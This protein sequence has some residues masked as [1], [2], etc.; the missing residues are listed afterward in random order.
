MIEMVIVPIE[1][2]AVARCRAMIAGCTL[3]QSDQRW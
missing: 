2:Q 1:G 3:C